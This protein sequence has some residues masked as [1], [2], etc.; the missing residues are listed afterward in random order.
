MY[1][2]SKTKRTDILRWILTSILIYGVYTETGKWTTV[3]I[4]CITIAIETN[5]L[6][7]RIKSDR[8]KAMGELLGIIGKR[9]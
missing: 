3:C 7:N 2:L 8:D 9:V 6:L 1:L 4:V 5:E